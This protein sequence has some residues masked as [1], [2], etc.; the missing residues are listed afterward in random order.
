SSLHFFL[1]SQSL[2][3]NFVVL[4]FFKFLAL[5]THFGK[6]FL[7]DVQGNV[8]QKF[9]ISTVKINQISLDDSGEH[10]GIC[11]EDGK[12]QVF[13]LYTREGFHDN[14]DCPIKLQLYERNWLNRWKTITLHEGEGI[15]TN[16]KWRGSL[17]AWANSLSVK[18]YDI[19]AKQRI[20]NVLRDNNSLRPDM[21]PCS[22]CWK[23]NTTLIIGWGTSVKI[24]IVK[25]RD[26][27]EMRDLPSRYVE[28]VSAF[29]TEF[30]ISGLAPLGDQIVI[31]YYVKEASEHQ[32]EKELRSRPRLDIVQPLPESYEEIS[33]DALTVRNFQENECLDYRLEHSEGESLFY[34]ISPKDIVVAKERDQDDHIDWL[35]D[36]KKYEEAL[37]AA[38]IS[39]KNIKRH[40]VQG[41]ATLIREWPGD[42]YNNMTIVQA[43]DKVVEELAHHPAMQH[44]YLHKLFKRDPHKGHKY[45]EMLISLYAEYDRPNL[46]P[47]LRDSTHCPLEKALE[48]CQQRNFVE[49][50]VF[51]LSRM[52]NSRRALQMIMEE[53]YDVDKAIEFAKEQDDA[54]LWE[55]LISYSIDKPPFITGLLNNIGTHVDPILLIHRIKE[56]MEIPNLRDSLVK[57]LHDYNLQVLQKLGKAD[58]TKDEQFEQF[59]Q[60]FKRQETEGTRLQKEMRGYLTAVK[61]MQEASMKLT[62]SLHEVYEPEWHGKDDV[63]TIGKTRI[64]KRSRKL[65]DYDSARHHLESLQNAKRR[66]DNKVTKAEEEFNKAQKVFEELNIDLQQE[67]PSLWDS[68]VGFY[69]N[70]FKNV[71]N[72]E[73]KFHREIAVLCHKLYEVMTKLG[74]QHADK[75][76][77]IQGAP[78]DTGPLR[79]AKTPSPPE[80]DSPPCS[81]EASPNHRLAPSS[82]APGRP[83]SPSQL[84][85]GPPVPPPP[86]LTPTK[87]LHQEQ[88]INFFDDNFVPEINVTTPLQNEGPTAMKGESLLDLDF[89]P[90]KPDSTTPIGKSQSP[91]SQASAEASQPPDSSKSLSL[92]NL[93]VDDN[94]KGHNAEDITRLHSDQGSSSGFAT[95]WGLDFS[96][97][98][99]SQEISANG[100][101]EQPRCQQDTTEEVN[102]LCSDLQ[103]PVE[104]QEWPQDENW[105]EAPQEEQADTAVTEVRTCKT[106][107]F[108]EQIVNDD[109]LHTVGE[110]EE[111]ISISYGLVN[112]NSEESEVVLADE[113]ISDHSNL[114]IM[115]YT[116]DVRE[117][118]GKE[119]SPDY[120]IMNSEDYDGHT[121][122]SEESVKSFEAKERKI[123]EEEVS[124]TEESVREVMDV[125]ENTAFEKSK[126]S[127]WNTI[128]EVILQNHPAQDIVLKSDDQQSN[129]G[130]LVSNQNIAKGLETETTGN[131]VLVSKS[132][133][134]DGAEYMLVSDLSTAMPED[135]ILQENSQSQVIVSPLQIKGPVEA[136]N[137]TIDQME[138]SSCAADDD[139]HAGWSSNSKNN[140]ELDIST[141]QWAS[142]KNTIWPENWEPTVSNDDWGFSSLPDVQSNSF[143]QWS[144]FPEEPGDQ[145]SGSSNTWQEVSDSSGFWSTEGLGDFGTG[146]GD[147]SL[148]DDSHKDERLSKKKSA[149]EMECNNLVQ[150]SKDLAK[151]Q[152]H[153]QMQNSRNASI[154][155]ST[156]PK[157]NETNSSDLS[158][159]EIANRRYGLLYREIDA[160]KEEPNTEVPPAVESQSPEDVTEPEQEVTSAEPAENAVVKQTIPEVIIEPASNNE[161]EDEELDAFNESETVTHERSDN[162]SPP[163]STQNEPELTEEKLQPEVESGQPDVEVKP[164]TTSE[165][166]FPK[167]YKY[168]VIVLHDFQAANSDELELKKDD[169]VLVI[170]CERAED[171]VLHFDKTEKIHSGF[172]ELNNEINKPQATYKLKLANRLYG[173]KTFNFQKNESKPV[174]MMYQMGKFPF[175]YIPEM[176]VKVLE[177]P[178]IEEELSMFVLL[179]DDIDDGSTG[180]KQVL[181]DDLLAALPGMVEVLHGPPEALQVWSVP[182]LAALSGVAEVLPSRALRWSRCPLAVAMNPN[183]VEPPSCPSVTLM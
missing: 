112:Q 56:G 3:I 82:P 157:D 81:P 71:T 48:I 163:A 32:E 62:E 2:V 22:L 97:S 103:E 106:H 44:V 101:T 21:Y 88:I 72:L 176:K 27:T 75:A 12:I 76:F 96:T 123:S 179:P 146:W 124:D 17:V 42:L 1:A 19:N 177:L 180:L 52:G 170:P 63:L 118:I 50:T 143:D 136:S 178:Y 54:E 154:E 104:G 11:S 38:E 61:G 160:E 99:V 155:S 140:E 98:S 51:L 133:A 152:G 31:L 125:N 89:D 108:Q 131:V 135:A 92:C 173:E 161:E 65:V 139:F 77:T 70:T 30:F 168:K 120:D 41:F 132:A 20:T 100:D 4:F 129:R 64:A 69:V 35:L 94:T 29:D 126:D 23:D 158:E 113:N 119:L 80:E 110:K 153:F 141:D 109:P 8:T 156:S 148:P 25:E 91:I 95:D 79:L 55:D 39:H 114:S 172:Q 67:L 18:I 57:I 164:E 34:I 28:I 128:T 15:I 86:K 116:E 174:K 150:A 13:G 60:N 43:I 53:L 78:S 9:D 122:E 111:R 46:L 83:K 68:R 137:K 73:S 16:V 105:Q 159:D 142:D 49:E 169:I 5:G 40:E 102:Q 117:H 14:F 66:D 175:N 107:Q 134:G 147:S 36:K 85:K 84:R 26:P 24:C 33:S 182:L 171:Q 151:T 145:E 59:V 90:F 58:E 6:V 45:H 144:A 93:A 162:G 87:E 115:K 10:V 127:I 7:L 181:H 37:M 74:E 149:W 165:Q 130:H 166:S 47:F 183:R 121:E 167:G 138:D